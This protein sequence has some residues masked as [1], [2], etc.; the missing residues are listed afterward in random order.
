MVY[1]TNNYFQTRKLGEILAR[2]I[3]KTKPKSKALVVGL[4][5][6]LGGGK[7]TFLQGLAR[8]LGIN[9]KILSPTFV[10]MRK[11]EVRSTKKRRKRSS[12][13]HTSYFRLYHIDCYRIQ[14]PKE[15]LELGFKKIVSDPQNIAAIEWA[16]RIQKIVPKDAIWIEFE[17]IDKKTRKITVKNQKSKFKNGKRKKTPHYY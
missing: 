16:D 10:I 1:L 13:L 17:F 3:L 5:G 14:K 9:Q 6:D 15:I 11:Y 8:G 4:E 12:G 7:T 2:E